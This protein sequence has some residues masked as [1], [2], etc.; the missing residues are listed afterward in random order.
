M[1]FYSIETFRLHM[2][3]SEEI[4]ALQ[5]LNGNGRFTCFAYFPRYFYNLTSRACE[6]FIYGGCGG[7]E[8]SFETKEKCEQFCLGKAIKS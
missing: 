6:I 3:I 4:C 2:L 5:P 8:N 1:S 7:N